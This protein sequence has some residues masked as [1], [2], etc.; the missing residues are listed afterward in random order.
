M[1][2]KKQNK[3]QKTKQKKN[4]KTEVETKKYKCEQVDF[5][6]Y[7]KPEEKRF[8]VRNKKILLDSGKDE[9][10]K[11]WKSIIIIRFTHGIIDSVW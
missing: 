5:E 9:M 6:Y 1:Y 11:I 7:W 10:N 3:K 2:R 8:K 4:R